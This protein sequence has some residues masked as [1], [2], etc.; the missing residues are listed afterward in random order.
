MTLNKFL[1]TL[2]L[3]GVIVTY[4]QVNIVGYAPQFKSKNFS[5][6]KEEDFISKKRRIVQ[7]TIVNDKGI[8]KFKLPP[9]PIE[10]YFIGMDD[11]YGYLYVQDGA[12]Y[13]IEFISDNPQNLS[14]NLQEEVELNFFDLDSNDI[15]YKILG[16]EAWLDYSLSELHFEE[17]NEA[18]I[19]RKISLVKLQI[20]KDA[21]K[22]SSAFF[23]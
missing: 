17:N 1:L 8:F 15:N 4:A 18:E 9:G 14:Y 19:L 13:K 16:F 22:D 21:Q 20:M 5:I 7:D 6:W 11:I 10:K 3:Q 12:T 2:L 23:R